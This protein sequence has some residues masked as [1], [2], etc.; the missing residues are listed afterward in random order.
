MSKEFWDNIKEQRQSL[1]LSL[2]DI[3]KRTKINLEIL[4]GIEEGDFTQLPETYMRLFL[5]S[6]A[7]EVKLDYQELLNNTGFLPESTNNDLYSVV[8]KN[9][10]GEIDK[11][12]SFPL[13]QNKNTSP[14]YIV[15]AVLVLAFL[16]FIIKKV[17]ENSDFASR[18]TILD[19]I[20]QAAP[21]RIDSSST[22][23]QIKDY[24]LLS[25][26]SDSVVFKF[27]VTVEIMPSEILSY[28]IKEEGKTPRELLLNKDQLH[29]ITLST[30]VEILLYRPNKC[31]VKINKT[32]LPMPGKNRLMIRL[33]KSGKLNL[34]E[35]S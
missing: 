32:V 34:E 12:E 24:V 18:A 7:R 20:E 4:Q 21:V 14:V 3:S 13:K 29:T 1:G 35:V 17:T 15:L 5:K 8:R 16:I 23:Q 27:P 11:K 19:T 25:E 6:Y 9:E 10:A 30:G 28:R 22:D 2:K 31:E 26:V 33:D